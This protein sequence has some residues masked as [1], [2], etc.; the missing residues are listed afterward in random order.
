MQRFFASLL[1]IFIC[2]FV[3]AQEA[4]SPANLHFNGQSWWEKVKVIA[5]DKMEGRDTGSAGERAPARR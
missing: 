2:V 5:D 3:S 4:S 1:F